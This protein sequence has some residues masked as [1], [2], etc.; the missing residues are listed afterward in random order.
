MCENILP[1]NSIEIIAGDDITLNVDFLFDNE[2]GTFEAKDTAEMLIHGDNEEI[3]IEA[4][5]VENNTA[6]FYLS[7]AFTQSLLKEGE[8]ESFYEYCVCA[9]WANKGRH[10]PIH[11]KRLTVKRC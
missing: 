4:K 1:D 2:S 8:S 9:N 3:T 7:S 5:Q 6:S 11:R 10:T